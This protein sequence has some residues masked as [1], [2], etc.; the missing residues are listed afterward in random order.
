MFYGQK[1][2]REHVWEQTQEEKYL[3]PSHTA[4]KLQWLRT[5]W[6]VH[7]WK[8]SGSEKSIQF[9][10]PENYGWVK[11]KQGYSFHWDTD[12]HIMAIQ[13][14]VG[15]LTTGCKCKKKMHARQS[16]VDANTRD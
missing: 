11:G 1:K 7:M 10:P 12:E 6:I 2:I 16:N 8:Q 9:L 3:L 13:R 5:V 14:K 4:L 15:R